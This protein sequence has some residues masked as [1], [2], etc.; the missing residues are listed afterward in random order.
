MR[1]GLTGRILFIRLDI[2]PSMVHVLDHQLTSLL[3][4][5]HPISATT[6]FLLILDTFCHI[7]LALTLAVI[8]V[9]LPLGFSGGSVLFDTLP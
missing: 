4:T 6:V 1:G 2:G 7:I 8:L 5:F 9:L 3:W